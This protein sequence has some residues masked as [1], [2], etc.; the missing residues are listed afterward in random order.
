MT[1]V[2]KTPPNSPP[3]PV[4]LF[5][6]VQR[7]SCGTDIISIVES[8][9][10]ITLQTPFVIEQTFIPQLAFKTFRTAALESIQRAAVSA[11]VKTTRTGPRRPP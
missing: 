3:K 1:S 8:R 10:P 7:D 6:F 2:P 4:P 11:D 9:P 5:M